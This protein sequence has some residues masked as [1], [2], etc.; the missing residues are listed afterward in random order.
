MSTFI[1]YVKYKGN[2]LNMPKK[3][4]LNVTGKESIE[5]LKEMI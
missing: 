1:I 4:E 5:K 3:F 2:D